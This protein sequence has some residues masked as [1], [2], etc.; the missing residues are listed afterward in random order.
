MFCPFTKEDCK[1]GCVFYVSPF[2]SQGTTCLIADK[3]KEIS[4]NQVIIL[5]KLNS[6]N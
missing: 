6:H 5:E 2:S 1:N 4:K 3:L